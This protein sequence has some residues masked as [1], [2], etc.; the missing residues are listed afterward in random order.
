MS[1]IASEPGSTV[2]EPMDNPDHAHE[3]YHSR[4][5]AEVRQYSRAVRWMKIALPVGALVLIGL[6]FLMGRDRG[7]LVDLD[8]AADAAAISAGLKLENPRFAGVTDEGDPFV[9]TAVSALPDSASPERIA[10]EQPEGEIR[11][12]GGR[13]VKVTS[14]NGEIFRKEERLN[15]SGDVLLSTSDGYRIRTERVELDLDR[16]TAMTPGSVFAV[17]PQGRIQADRVQIVTKAGDDRDVTI[18]F[19]GNVQVNYRPKS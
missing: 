14:T 11:M 8:T 2:V 7:A 1:T 4:R 15:L 12:S 17:G 10:L 9:V 18:R 16:R 13:V 5:A 6:I 19:E 3:R